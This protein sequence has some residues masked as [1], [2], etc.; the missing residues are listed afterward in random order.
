MVMRIRAPLQEFRREMSNY[1]TQKKEKKVNFGG[2][3]FDEVF[4]ITQ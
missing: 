2:S 1:F 4:D 3:T